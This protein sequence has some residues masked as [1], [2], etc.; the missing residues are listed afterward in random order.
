MYVNKWE[1]EKNPHKMSSQEKTPREKTPQKS[2]VEKTPHPIL[3]LVEKTPQLYK[4]PSFWNFD[5]FYLNCIQTLTP[6]LYKKPSYWNFCLLEANDF[7]YMT[8]DVRLGNVCW[9]FASDEGLR[10]LVSEQ[11][12][13]MDGTF[14][15]SVGHNHPS[16]WRLITHLKEDEALV[17]I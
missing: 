11:S 17:R 4:K 8:V 10:H 12:W 15:H 2:P 14:A 6:P 5:I 1:T 3:G 16:L 7:S 13:Y 9:F